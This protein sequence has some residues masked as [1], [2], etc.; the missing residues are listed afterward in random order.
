MLLIRTF[1]IVLSLLAIIFFL[2]FF[3]IIT[4]I[5]LCDNS[6]PVLFTQKRITIDQKVFNFV[7]FR[8][9]KHSCSSNTGDSEKYLTMDLEELKKIRDK[10]VTTRSGDSRVTN[11]GKILRKSSLDEIPQ[12]FSVLKGDMS[13]VGPRPDPP[14]QKADY[15]PDIWVKRCKVKSG[16]TGLAQING[17]SAGG[18][19]KRIENDIYWSEHISIL[20]YLKILIRTPFVLLRN[21]N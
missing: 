17:R 21:S 4:V 5:L 6:G 16:I 3:I 19:A 12:F 7:K 2:P 11:F 14:I 10:Y 8:S 1:D 9:M 15:E 18:L 13:M 20:L